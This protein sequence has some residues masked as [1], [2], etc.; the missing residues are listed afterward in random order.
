MLQLHPSRRCN[1]A[2]AHCYTSSGPEEREELGV[3]LLSACLSDAVALGYAQL[4]VSGGEP[5]LYRALPELLARG[6]ALGMLTTL[7]TNGMRLNG[8][9]WAPIA[10]LV[11]RLAISIDGVEATHD[12]MRRQRG[13]F[14]RTV[15]N[16]ET[17][18]HSRAS[19]GFI[20]TLTQHNVDELEFVVRLAAEQGAESV[21]VHPLTLNGR[22]QFLL[23]ESR[24]DGV[25]LSAALAEALRLGAELGV[26]VHVDALTVDQLA[27]HPE[28]LIPARPV[29]RLCD[30]APVLVVAADGSVLPLTSDLAPEHSLGSL[31][32]AAL[33]SLAREWLASGQ[34]DR[35]AAVCEHTWSKLAARPNGLAYY[36]YEEVAARSRALRLPLATKPAV[37]YE[38]F[39][40]HPAR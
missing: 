23:S 1:L 21:Q 19:F 15:R 27:Q 10:P 3:E 22:A 28:Y 38:S 8:R 36:W 40:G 31:R 35:L 25:E 6:R 32:A 20:F 34:G 4:A 2:C 14:A 5:L 18:R 12:A 16:L 30:V 11:D 24:P 33:S 39:D 17:L 37:R 26:A 29:L 13:A 7:T 9:T